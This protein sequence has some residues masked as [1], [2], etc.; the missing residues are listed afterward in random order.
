MSISAG[1]STVNWIE[2]EQDFTMSCSQSWFEKF[3]GSYEFIRGYYA[4]G[5]QDKSATYSN[6]AQT[7][8]QSAAVIYRNE[9]VVPQIC[10]CVTPQRNASKI[11]LSII[12][13]IGSMVGLHSLLRKLIMWSEPVANR[14]GC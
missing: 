9:P 3:S 11:I 1:A 2:I 4:M 8:T 10:Q 12:S 13:F 14:F 6:P 7:S 5:Y